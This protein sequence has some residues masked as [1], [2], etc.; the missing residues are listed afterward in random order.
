[1]KLS[2]RA[3]KLKTDV[4]AV[5]FALKKKETPWYA[6]IV[7]AIVV[8]YA[9]SDKVYRNRIASRADVGVILQ[10]G[11]HANFCLDCFDGKIDTEI[12]V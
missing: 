12:G 8:I 4:P 5:F 1:M 3:K 11:Y 2:E 7:A 6:K 10:A 9:L